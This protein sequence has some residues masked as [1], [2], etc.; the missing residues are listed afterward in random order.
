MKINQIMKAQLSY[1]PHQWD[2]TISE[3]EFLFLNNNILWDIRMVQIGLAIPHQI[4]F[5]GEWGTWGMNFFVPRVL[6]NDIF[7][8]GD[9][10]DI[11]EYLL[12]NFVDIERK[13]K[14]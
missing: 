4:S 14:W 10:K 8:L 12:F 3:E 5:L 11:E 9:P 2:T 7:F 1:D 13:K 6:G